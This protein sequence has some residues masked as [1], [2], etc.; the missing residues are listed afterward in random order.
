MNAFTASI[1]PAAAEIPAFLRAAMLTS[2]DISAAVKPQEYIDGYM[3]PFG[4]CTVLATAGGSGKTTSSIGGAVSVA[5]SGD[6]HLFGHRQHGRPLKT[7]LVFG[8][9]TPDMIARKLHHELPGGYSA[10]RAAEALG[11]VIIISWSTFISG[12]ATPEKI[13]SEKGDLTESGRELFD[14]IE[15]YKPEFVLFDTLSSLSDGD[16]M[17]DRVAYSTMR[18]LNNLTHKTGAAGIITSHLVKGGASKVDEKSCAD[19]LIALS[20]GSAAL[21]N[22]ARHAIVLVPSPA[23][24]FPGVQR[25]EGE[26]VWMCGVKSNLGFAGAGSVFPVIRSTDLRTFTAFSAAGGSVAEEADAADKMMVRVLEDYLLGLIHYAA[27]DMQ[28]FAESGKMSPE[29]LYGDLLAP[30]LPKGASAGQVKRAVDNLIR[31][32][33][34]KVCRST[35]TGTPVLDVDGGPF[36]NPELHLDEKGKEPKFRKG[37]PDVRALADRVIRFAADRM[38]HREGP[39]AKLPLPA[40]FDA[41]AV[42]ELDVQDDMPM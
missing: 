25:K 34:V 28:P 39:D 15:A 9:E 36:A 13:W 2:K 19:D 26:S 18:T 30:V 11:N 31:S 8:E 32:E 27:A 4:A 10:F 42:D 37:A 21:V 6:F 7:V 17:Q 41:A 3:L 16:Y 29:N 12:R 33:H 20:R 23:G 40:E 35:A 38:K 5:S 1:R 24:A 22:A 14:A